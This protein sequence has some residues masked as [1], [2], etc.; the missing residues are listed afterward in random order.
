MYPGATLEGWI[1]FEVDKEDTKPLMRF[2][3]IGG[4]EELWF[5]LY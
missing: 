5:K 2:K 3:S 1:A 4:E